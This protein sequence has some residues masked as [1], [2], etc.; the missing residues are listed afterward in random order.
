MYNFIR[1]QRSLLA[2]ILAG[3]T[4]SGLWITAGTMTPLAAAPSSTTGQECAARLADPAPLSTAEREWLETCVGAFTLPTATTT[5]TVPPTTTTVPPTT[6]STPPTSTTPPVTTGPQACPAYPAFPDAACTGVPAGVTLTSYTGP[7]TITTANTVI[8]S[9]LVNCQLRP[10]A[11]GIV[12]RNSRIVGGVYGATGRN[13]PSFTVTDSD[14]IAP[15]VNQTE[16]NGL[17][18]ANF[19]AI[20]VDVTG[21]NRGVYC[22]FNCVLRDSWVH[23]T[24]IASNSAAHASAVRQSQ[25]NLIIHNRLQCQANDNSAGGGCSADLTGYGD[26]EAVTNN[27]VE[28]NLFMATPGGACAYGGS[29]GDDGTKP[30]G[31]QAHDIVF[32]DNVFEHGTRRGDHG[33]FN[34]GFYF[35]IT[36]FNSAR[37]G[38]QWINNRWDSGEVLPPAN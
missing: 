28:K 12:I 18:E 10:M 2:V 17:G 38:N 37:P 29:S 25:G 6:T 3:F 24:N 35:P 33:T 7:C 34:C 30:F 13:A 15:Q 8:D 4:V 14:L 1:N 11:A 36:D 19:T 27:R 9:K 22:R 21:G 31:N 26:F 32:V 16:A 23:G 5:T 20:R